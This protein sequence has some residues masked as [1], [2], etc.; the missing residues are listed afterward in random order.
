MVQKSINKNMSCRKEETNNRVYNQNELIYLRDGKRNL[1][2]GKEFSLL[3]ALLCQ[4]KCQRIAR[5]IYLPLMISL[6]L[7]A[8]PYK[9]ILR[10]PYSIMTSEIPLSLQESRDLKRRCISMGL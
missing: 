3:I 2:F 9:Q 10:E 8:I 5:E 4:T 7:W 1:I 6:G